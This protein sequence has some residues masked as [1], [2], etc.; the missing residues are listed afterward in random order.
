MTDEKIYNVNII[1][2]DTFKWIPLINKNSPVLNYGIKEPV[3]IKLLGH[4]PSLWILNN[5]TNKVMTYTN[6]T[7][8]NCGGVMIWLLRTI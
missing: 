6:Y 3:L 5:E 7:F 8:N 2:R 4:F 1:S